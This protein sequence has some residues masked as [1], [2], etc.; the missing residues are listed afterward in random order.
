MTETSPSVRV[1]DRERRAVDDRLQAAVGDGVLTLH[2]YE[3]RSTALWQTRTRADLDRLV[4]DLPPEDVARA[5]WPAP[6]PTSSRAPRQDRSGRRLTRLR[7]ARGLLVPAAVLGAVLLVGPD[8]ISVF[9][10]SVERVAPDDRNV[11]VSALFGSV[12]VVVPDGRQVDTTDRV[13]F[14]S[15]D[16]ELACAGQDGPVVNVRTL[17][18]FGS[19]RVVTQAEWRAERA[20]RVDEPD[21]D[22]DD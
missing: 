10:S 2:E 6:V 17:G 14:G 8:S 20:E 19:V 15:T 5:A 11:W 21:V 3:Q 12:T 1:G 18:G 9:G 16:C 22:V 7:R 13:V 4:A